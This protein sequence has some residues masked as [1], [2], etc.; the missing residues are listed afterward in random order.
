MLENL[1]RGSSSRL[2]SLAFL[3]NEFAILCLMAG[4]GTRS[5]AAKVYTGDATPADRDEIKRGLRDALLLLGQQYRAGNVSEDTHVGN[6]RHFPAGL[7]D[8][9]AR[10]LSGGRLRFGVAQKVVNLY[11]KYMWVA[12][13]IG[14]P[15]HCPI[16]GLIAK[17][18]RIHYRWTTSDSEADYLQ[19]VAALHAKA[20]GQALADWELARFEEVRGSATQRQA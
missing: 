13:F 12:G 1:E 5:A 14:K 4:L 17:D 18:A 15:P 16:D 10:K 8:A 20:G 2:D 11:L 3:H 7:P 6:I 19:A 9:Q